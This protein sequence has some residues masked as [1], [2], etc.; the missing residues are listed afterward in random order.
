MLLN[1][2]VLVPQCKQS[3]T[4]RRIKRKYNLLQNPDLLTF[5]PYYHSSRTLYIKRLQFTKD[6]IIVRT[7]SSSEAGSIA[8]RG[9][10]FTGFALHRED[11]VQDEIGLYI[12]VTTIVSVCQSVWNR[13]DDRGTSFESRRQQDCSILLVFRQP[14]KPTQT[15]T[16]SVPETL[17]ESKAAGASRWPLTS[18]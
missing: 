2:S 3:Y 13:L 16:Q 4:Y 17:S 12:T 8:H 15:P 6:H 5:I 18:V 10:H 9:P 7:W 14:L 11:A 1:F